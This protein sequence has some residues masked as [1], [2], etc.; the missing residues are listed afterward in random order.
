MCK[1]A[2]VLHVPDVTVRSVE[3]GCG[4]SV[5]HSCG[6]ELCTKSVGT[7][8]AGEEDFGKNMNQIQNRDLGKCNNY[9]IYVDG[10]RGGLW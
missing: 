6:H 5:G 1:T 2:R 7:I 8:S 10:G 4:C 3:Q 9:D